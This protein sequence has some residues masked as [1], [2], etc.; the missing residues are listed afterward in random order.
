MDKNLIYMD[1][2]ATSFPKPREL[3]EAMAHY[4]NDIGANPGR[5][6]HHMSVEAGRV[7]YE[8][9][10]KV[11]E[12]LRAPDPM[13][14]AFALNATMGINIALFGVIKPGD[15]V[16]TSSLEH[17]SMARPLR[18]LES[19]G[20]ELTRV[21]CDA[22]TSE[23]DTD[24]LRGSIKPNTR[25]IAMM[26]AS[27]VS[28]YLFPVREIGALAKEYDILFIV[29]GA[30]TVGSVPVDVE[31]LNIDMLAFTGHKGMLGPQGTG[32]LYVRPGLIVKPLLMGGTGSRSEDDHH[33]GFMP[34]R[35]EAGTP[36]GIGLA[37]LGAGLDYIKDRGVDSIREHELALSDYFLKRAASIEKLTVHARGSSI[38]NYL[39]V[40]SVSIE[41][42]DSSEAARLM[43]VEY[44]IM[45]RSGLHCSPWA[46]KA[47]KT[48]PQ[49]TMRISFGAFTA[50]PEVDAVVGA[51]EDI[52]AKACR[53]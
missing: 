5:S 7:I 3:T 18:Y 31:D 49:G 51:L 32:G 1:N 2:A 20:V 4:S 30:Q 21:S 6:G 12:L 19:L 14:I 40:F 10:E 11:A 52:A 39:P 22:A 41:G 53:R 35:L 43:D 9:R 33:P 46:H 44:N 38:K 25:C 29:D 48:A 34:D 28:G 23:L 36:N 47:L 50:L 15:H 37:G 42:V 26:H 17:N 24:E 16:I 13:S 8:T 27:N 45:V